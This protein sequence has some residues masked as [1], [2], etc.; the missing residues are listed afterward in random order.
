[1]RADG[2]EVLID[3]NGYTTHA[4]SEIFAL[5]P[6]PVQISWLGYLGTLGAPWYDYVLTDRFAAP[7]ALQRYFSERFLYLPDCYCPS[8]TRREV[9]AVVPSRAACGLPERALVFCCFNN[10]YKILP[11]V[12]AL[13]LRLLTAQ[14]HSVLWLAPGNATAGANLRREAA[15]RGIDPQRLVLAPRVSLPEHL[16]RHAHADLFLD[17][18]P[19]NA[20]TTAN[21]ALFMGV[22]LLTC[23]GATMV[24]RVAGSQLRAAGLPELVTTN[25]AEYEALGLKFAAEPALL[26]SYRSR[27][28]EQ[29]QRS[30]LFDMARFTHALD[31]LLLAAWENRRSVEIL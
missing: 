7:A 13:W 3:L 6:A 22:P 11:E 23:S 28:A 26:Q 5:K 9:A 2:V 1:M 15:A 16:A 27:L 30:A 12:F 19:Y 10:S 4:R 18:T 14:P 25:L 29:R 31:D 17:T 24:S 8:D 21:D 20:G